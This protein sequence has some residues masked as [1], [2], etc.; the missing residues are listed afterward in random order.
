MS[1]RSLF[2]PLLACLLLGAVACKKEKA[3]VLDDAQWIR[4]CNKKLTDVIV[5]DIFTPP[6]ASRMYPYANVAAWEVLVQFNKGYKSMSGQLRGLDSIPQKPDKN[7]IDGLLAAS[8]AF[9]TV[10]QKAIYSEFEFDDFMKQLQDRAAKAG[11][12][13]ESIAESVEFGK[14]VASRILCWQGKDQFK[15]TRAMARYT[16]SNDAAKWRPT[17]TEY[18]EAIEPNWGTMRS[19]TLDSASQFSKRIPVD[20]DDTNSKMFE[21]MAKHTKE[22]N[23]TLT[24]EHTEMALFWD[25][26]PAVVQNVGHL[27][28][29][30]KK[31]TPPGHWMN[32]VG[33]LTR[34]KGLKLMPTAEAYLLASI[35]VFDG[36]ISCWYEKYKTET[37]RPVTYINE[38]MDK[39]WRPVLQTPPFPEFIS[40][41]SVISAAATTVLSNLLGGS[42][43]FSDS[44]QVEYGLGIRSFPNLSS[45]AREA[46]ISR[47]Y[48]G[49]HFK[50]AIDSGLDMGNSV[51]D[52]VLTKIKTK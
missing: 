8:I 31:T 12:S 1:F 23:D 3:V 48:G 7:N 43:A 13:E 45:A 11:L 14:K 39:S 17:P 47:V 46:G 30:N 5:V 35:A 33:Q 42:L 38:R 24:A 19:M 10:G 50:P 29:V 16:V 40:G 32:I 20:Y 44:T 37:I 25:D 9:S 2:F 52:Y 21:E 49:I 34:D 28:M 51:G 6:V 41:H 27:K 26:N 18:M 22:A 4:D 15:E 36:V